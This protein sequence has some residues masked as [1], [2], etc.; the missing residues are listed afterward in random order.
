MK[1]KDEGRNEH[2]ERQDMSDKEE[3]RNQDMKGN[4]NKHK[5][6]RDVADKDRNQDK[7]ESKD[8]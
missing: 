3:D 2:K 5:D 6:R 4:K 1:D 8:S 7:D